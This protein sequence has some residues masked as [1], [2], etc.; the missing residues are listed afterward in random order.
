MYIEEEPFQTLDIVEIALH[1]NKHKFR[2][3]IMNLE[4]KGNAILKK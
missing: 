2:K 3:M 4:N 1:N